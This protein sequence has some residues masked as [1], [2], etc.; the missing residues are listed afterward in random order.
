MPGGLGVADRLRGLFVDAIPLAVHLVVGN[1]VF[2]HGTEGAEAD[3][4]SHFGNVHALGAD[5][6]HQLRGKVQ[7]GRGSRS[8]AQLLCINGLILALVFQLL[9]DVG[10]QRHFAELVQF[11]IKRLGIIIE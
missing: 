10:R 1:L 9:R 4:Q 5:S 11:F 8:A 3:V 6:I 2:L 7:A